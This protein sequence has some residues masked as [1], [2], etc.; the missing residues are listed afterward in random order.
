MDVNCQCKKATVQF[1]DAVNYIKLKGDLT[2]A[3]RH[4]SLFFKVGRGGLIQQILTNQNQK[5]RLVLIEIVNII[6]CGQKVEG[7]SIITSLS[8]CINPSFHRVTSIFYMLPKKRLGEE[9]R[10]VHSFFL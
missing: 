10:P 3:S 4:V 2:S 8:F 6:I 9:Q 1:K 7:C 5:K